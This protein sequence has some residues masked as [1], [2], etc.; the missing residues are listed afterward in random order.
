MIFTLSLT[1]KGKQKLFDAAINLFE[2]QGY[3]A[4]TIEQITAE[5]GVSKGLVYHYFKS[6]EDTDCANLINGK[7]IQ[8]KKVTSIET[9]SELKQ[10]YME[11]TTAPLDGMWMAGFVPISRHF[12]FYEN[13]QLVGFFCINDDGY[14]LQFHV[15]PKKTGSNISYF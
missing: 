5:A 3:F 4:T 11:Q 6:K 1:Q 10:Q 12:G 2:S 15:S 7:M 13:D 9:L 8:I 14:L